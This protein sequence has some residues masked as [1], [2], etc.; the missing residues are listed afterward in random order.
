MLCATKINNMELI[1]TEKFNHEK[2]VYEIKLWRTEIGFKVQ[3]FLNEKP[4]NPYVYNIDFITADDYEMFYGENAS[5]KLVKL[6][7]SDIVDGL[8]FGNKL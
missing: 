6:A 8:V 1:K 3:S 5:E 2:L 7:I 4:A